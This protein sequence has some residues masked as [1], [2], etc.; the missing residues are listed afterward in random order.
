MTTISYYDLYLMDKDPEYKKFVYD[1]MAFEQ[2]PAFMFAEIIK[3][4]FRKLLK[5]VTK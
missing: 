5:A 3:T 4:P 1:Q 2:L